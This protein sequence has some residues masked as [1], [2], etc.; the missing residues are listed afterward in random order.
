MHIVCIVQTELMDE[1]C[2]NICPYMRLCYR[3][4]FSS[5][6]FR[7]EDLKLTSNNALHLAVA[8]L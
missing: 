4:R 1:K 5:Q 6:V 8:M 3:S 2:S 7:L